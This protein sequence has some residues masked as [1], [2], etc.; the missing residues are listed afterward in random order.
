MEPE[1]DYDF[2]VDQSVDELNLAAGTNVSRVVENVND[3]FKKLDQVVPYA[4]RTRE[5]FWE[6]ARLSSA[7][8]EDEEE[9]F[10]AMQVRINN[11]FQGFVN[12]AALSERDLI[13][14]VSDE[15]Y[16]KGIECQ[17][18]FG[19]S[20]IEHWLSLPHAIYIIANNLRACHYIAL[21]RSSFV[22][23]PD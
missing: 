18:A 3:I 6:K 12:C 10:S 11:D 16:S 15:F 13:T 22:F 5:V 4:G 1:A 23:S 2:E 20:I 8:K 19:P 21:A 17:V 7:P 14:F 9:N